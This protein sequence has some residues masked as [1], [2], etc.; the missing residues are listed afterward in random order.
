[1]AASR[2]LPSRAVQV[3]PT[4]DKAVPAPV[5]VALSILRY[6]ALDTWRYNQWPLA[7]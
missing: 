1:M 4:L 6:A 5:V 2:L 3:E 7:P